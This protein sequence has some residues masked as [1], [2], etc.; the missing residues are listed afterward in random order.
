MPV[1]TSEAPQTQPWRHFDRRKTALPPVPMRLSAPLPP[2]PA[3]A[4]E[5]A[6]PASASH[7]GEPPQA[8]PAKYV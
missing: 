2:S 6:R 1:L 5:E 3:P 8:A 4:K 7:T